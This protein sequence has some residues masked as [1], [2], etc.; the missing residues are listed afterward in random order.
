MVADSRRKLEALDT[1]EESEWQ[2]LEKGATRK[3]LSS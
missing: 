3:K 1:E 2:V